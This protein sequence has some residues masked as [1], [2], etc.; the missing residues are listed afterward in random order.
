MPKN[1]INEYNTI[2]E[3][4]KA[5]LKKYKDN[6]SYKRDDFFNIPWSDSCI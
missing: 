2:L 6:L 5:T 3:V 1:L 4:E